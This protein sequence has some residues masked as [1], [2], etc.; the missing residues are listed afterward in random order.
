[1]KN[2]R[3]NDYLSQDENVKTI[4]K[5]GDNG[6]S[7]ILKPCRSGPL[8][9]STRKL[10]KNT[11]YSTDTGEMVTGEMLYKQTARALQHHVTSFSSPLIDAP[12]RT[13]TSLISRKVKF[14]PCEIITHCWIKFLKNL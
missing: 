14:Y 3:K 9:K 7:R 13:V 2:F 8:A 11:R 1:M 12:S 5:L 4:M 10:A 6:S